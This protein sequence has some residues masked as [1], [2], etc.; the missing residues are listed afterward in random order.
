MV[1]LILSVWCGLWIG[2]SGRGRQ[3]GLTASRVSGCLPPQVSCRASSNNGQV[4]RMWWHVCSSVPHLH[5]AMSRVPIILLAR[6]MKLLPAW[7]SS[8]CQGGRCVADSRC[9]SL[10]AKGLALACLAPFEEYTIW[11][12]KLIP[13]IPVLSDV[14]REV[15]KLIDSG[16]PVMLTWLSS[17]IS[18]F[19]SSKP[20][21]C[22]FQSLSSQSC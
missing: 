6:T 11:Y 15:L 21:A 17:D 5:C 1:A 18:L 22:L 4:C 9:S 8:L 2:P 16:H 12:P 3:V 20:P 14:G 13:V 19:L 7:E 10:L